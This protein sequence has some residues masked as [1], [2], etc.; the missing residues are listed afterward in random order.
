MCPERLMSQPEGEALL[1]FSWETPGV[2]TP[3]R[4]HMCVCES[5][6]MCVCACACV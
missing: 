4:V 5:L 3:V 6:C 2:V 1:Q